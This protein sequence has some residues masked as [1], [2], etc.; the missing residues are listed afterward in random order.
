[1]LLQQEA[2]AIEEFIGVYELCLALTILGSPSFASFRPSLI[3]VTFMFQRPAFRL[4][5]QADP[6]GR[7]LIGTI[8]NDMVLAHLSWA[9]LGV[10]GGSMP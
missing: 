4:F 6:L 8:L 5:R 7:R 9:A 2:P 10:I 3:L 1:M